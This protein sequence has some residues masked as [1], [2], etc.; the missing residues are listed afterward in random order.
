MGYRLHDVGFQVRFSAAV[1]DFSSFQSV[2][3][4][5]GAHPLGSGAPDIGGSSVCN[6]ICITHLTPGR[7]TW[8]TEF[9][10]ICVPPLNYFEALHSVHSCSQSLL[11]IPT[12]CT[13]VCLVGIKRSDTALLLPSRLTRIVYAIFS[14]MLETMSVTGFSLCG[15][16]SIAL[17]RNKIIWM[18]TEARNTKINNSF[19]FFILKEKYFVFTVF[20]LLLEASEMHCMMD[21]QCELNIHIILFY[22]SKCPNPV[23]FCNF[24]VVCI[25]QFYTPICT[26]HIKLYTHNSTCI[27]D[28]L[29]VLHNHTYFLQTTLLRAIFW[30]FPKIPGRFAE[31][32]HSSQVLLF[33]DSHQLTSGQFYPPYIHLVDGTVCEHKVVHLRLC[34][35]PGSLC[36]QHVSFKTIHIQNVVWSPAFIVH[37]NKWTDSTWS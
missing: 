24:H 29:H 3:T 19:L 30:I 21:R 31:V 18:Q 10:K 16:N 9:R 8:F 6:L 26:L 13:Y 1:K 25:I 12:K 37:F 15:H 33:L 36:S 5:S 17:S 34:T 20:L 28:L 11:F 22:M 7:R 35:R 4:N 14:H 2:R 27:P 32:Q 23:Q